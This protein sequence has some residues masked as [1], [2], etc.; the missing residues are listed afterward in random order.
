MKT[1]HVYQSDA[2]QT[3]SKLKNVELQ[4]AKVEQQL[5]GKVSSSRKLKGLERQTEKVTCFL[6]WSRW[7]G[8]G[9]LLAEDHFWFKFAVL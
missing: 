3:E 9:C 2:K 6:W 1:Y 5:L 7:R 4:K 8:S